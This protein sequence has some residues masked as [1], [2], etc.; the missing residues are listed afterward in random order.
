MRNVSR[1][2]VRVTIA[3]PAPLKLSGQFALFT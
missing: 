1:L 2:M 3:F